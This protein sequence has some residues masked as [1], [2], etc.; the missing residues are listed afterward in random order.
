MKEGP[1][2]IDGTYCDIKFSFDVNLDGIVLENTVENE[3]TVGNKVFSKK[4][5]CEECGK[6][7]GRESVLK[8]RKFIHKASKPFKCEEC[9][10]SFLLK[11]HLKNHKLIHTKREKTLYPFG[12]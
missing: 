1:Q 3:V 7:Y 10:M 6:S 5:K 4:F 12:K 8:R 11:G 9:G 2:I